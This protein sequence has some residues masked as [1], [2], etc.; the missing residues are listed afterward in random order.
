[1]RDEKYN[2]E[3]FDVTDQVNPMDP[4]NPFGNIDM[5]N[6][7]DW[8]HDIIVRYGWDSKLDIPP[9]LK[10]YEPVLIE[11]EKIIL[12]KHRKYVDKIG[13]SSD[14]VG[15]FHFKITKDGKDA[16]IAFGYFIKPGLYQLFFHMFIPDQ[17]NSLDWVYTWEYEHMIDNFLKKHNRPFNRL[18]A[19]VV[20]KSPLAVHVWKRKAMK[21]WTKTKNPGHKRSYTYNINFDFQRE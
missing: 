14:G 12:K 20:D 15:P 8:N 11:F 18:F 9:A 1:M 16:Y 5:E 6:F 17:Y 13:I 2:L 4:I 10:T 3:M 21:T 7:W 19:T